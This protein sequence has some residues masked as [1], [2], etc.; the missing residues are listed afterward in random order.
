L[1]YTITDLGTFPGYTFSTATGVN[2][3]GQAVGYDFTSNLSSAR[4]YLYD[5]GSLTDLGSLGG[6]HVYA[7]GINDLGQVAGFSQLPGDTVSHAFRYDSG[8]LTDLAPAGGNSYG[9]A[10][11]NNGD[12]TGYA[13]TSDGSFHAVLWQGTAMTDLGTL[14]GS[15]SYGQAINDVDMVVG[16]SYLSGNAVFHAFLAWQGRMADLGTLPG[17]ANSWAYGVNNVGQVVGFS[18]NSIND[19]HAF[20]WDRVNGMQDLGTLGGVRSYANAINDVGQVVGF[21][22]LPNGN[23]D[24]FLYDSGVMTDLNDLLPPGSGWNV[25]Q[26]ARINNAGQIVG[27]GFHNG[28]Q[29]GFLMTPD[30][31]PSAF[32]PFQASAPVN[33]MASVVMPVGALDQLDGREL[34]RLQATMEVRPASQVETTS[35]PRAISA[36]HTTN[37]P[38]CSLEEARDWNGT[39]AALGAPDQLL[40]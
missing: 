36:D 7:Q 27:E 17:S 34:P 40:S 16:L 38:G 1:S 10:I 11:N 13:A 29:H 22:A 35:A 39:A 28:A 12:V 33:A 18:G 23:Q 9:Y 32:P 21:A 19:Y 30:A 24:A 2:A 4:A 3:S 5:S 8:T 14:G 25:Y 6:N 26:A 20:L 15:P 37:E 31:S